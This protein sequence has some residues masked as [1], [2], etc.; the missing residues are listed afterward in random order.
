MEAAQIEEL[1]EGKYFFL[2]LDRN[3]YIGEREGVVVERARNQ[4]QAKQTYTHEW[5]F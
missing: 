4:T 2:W 1:L 5:T 3:L